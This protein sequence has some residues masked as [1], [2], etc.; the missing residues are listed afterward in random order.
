VGRKGRPATYRDAEAV[1]VVD[2]HEGADGDRA[3]R[4][5]GSDDLDVDDL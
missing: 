4:R 5:Q 3:V 2:A 1:G